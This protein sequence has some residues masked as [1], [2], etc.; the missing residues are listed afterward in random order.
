MKINKEYLKQTRN[1]MKMLLK[2]FDIILCQKTSYFFNHS[3]NEVA[4]K[5]I[6]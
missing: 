1:R 6:N 3:L 5:H 4:K 2:N